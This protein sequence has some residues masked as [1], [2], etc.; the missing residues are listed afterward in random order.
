MFTVLKYISIN[1]LLS[2]FVT[3]SD[4]SLQNGKF[5]FSVYNKSIHF[6]RYRL[7]FMLHGFS[8]RPRTIEI[9]S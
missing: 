8:C 7:E 3:T 5:L 9:L 4:I 2:V 6:D 1:I